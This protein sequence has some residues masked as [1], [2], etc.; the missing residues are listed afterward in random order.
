MSASQYIGVDIG[1]T[2]IRAARFVGENHHPASKTKIATQATKGVETILQRLEM[3]VRE[4][5]GDHLSAINGIGIA[6]AG[7]LDPN[8]GVVLSAPNL[9]GWENLPLRRTMQERLAR[10]VYIGNDANMAALGEWKFGAG[11]GHND[12]LYLTLSTGIG[13]GVIAGGQMLVGARGLATEVG[14]MLAV[15]DGPLCGCGQ[16]GHLEAVA[17]GTAIARLARVKLK[18]GD[19]AD[20]RLWELCSGD[21]DSITGALVGQAA[22]AGDEFARRLIVEAGTFIGRTVASLLHCLNPSVVICGGGVSML[23]DVILEPIRAA[24]RQHALSEAYWRSCPIVPAALGDDAG[25]IGAGAL[26]MEETRRLAALP[27]M[28]GG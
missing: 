2:S 11:Q 27:A 6:A 9:P 25:L 19:G 14:H 10:P 3:A 26:A 28:A 16:R 22:Q 20:S 4:V 5:A 7:P 12:V 23:G 24:V 17:S 8:T 21:L 15:P 1:G 13:G 18:A